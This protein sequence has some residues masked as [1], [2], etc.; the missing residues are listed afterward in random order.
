MT[1]RHPDLAELEL[2]A[3]HAYQAAEHRR[4][5]ENFNLWREEQG[6]TG[7]GAGLSWLTDHQQV[8]GHRK[9]E[10]HQ[11]V[12]SQPQGA[13]RPATPSASDD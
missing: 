8:G 12:A 13:G 6:F 1:L 3:L 2:T 11:K 4:W 7:P 10:G 9:V 5:A